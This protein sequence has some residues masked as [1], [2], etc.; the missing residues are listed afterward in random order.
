MNNKNRNRLC[1]GL[2]FITASICILK[3]TSMNTK[4]DSTSTKGYQEPKDTSSSISSEYVRE[5]SE[6]E[7]SIVTSNDTNEKRFNSSNST[8]NSKVASSSDTNNL[9]DDPVTRLSKYYSEYTAYV[10]FGD[11]ENKFYLFDFDSKKG[12]C[13]EVNGLF[14]LEADYLIGFNPVQLL[15]CLTDEEK[16]IFPDGRNVE[17]IE[18]VRENLNRIRTPQEIVDDLN[19]K[20]N[21]F[22]KKYVNKSNAEIL[23][24]VKKDANKN[25]EYPINLIKIITLDENA[26]SYIPVLDIGDGVYYELNGDNFWDRTSNNIR[27]NFFDVFVSYYCGF[28]KQFLSV[29]EIYEVTN[30]I[31]QDFKPERSSSSKSLTR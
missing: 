30:L 2:A 27:Y 31:S 7:K 1:A 20:L 23:K 28:N 25:E 24:Q 6:L 21:D 16:Q 3:L 22:N 26:T 5:E 11:F 13:T 8:P 9:D 12:I 15:N 18:E 17:T 19:K 4:S 29:E 10:H 14:T